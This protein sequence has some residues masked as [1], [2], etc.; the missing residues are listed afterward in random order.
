MG[1]MIAL[2]VAT[3]IVSALVGPAAVFTRETHEGI[4]S[5]ATTMA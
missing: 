2:V 5:G 4:T 3:G 1:F